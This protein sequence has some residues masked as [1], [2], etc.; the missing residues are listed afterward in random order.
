MAAAFFDAIEREHLAHLLYELGPDAPTL[1]GP[2]T[3]RDLA[4]HLVLREHDFFAG[5]GLVI[6]GVWSRFAERRREALVQ[7][8]FSRLVAAIRSGPPRGFFR[9]KWVR[10]L[11][12]LNEFFVHHEDVRR[13][14]G[15]AP[16]TNSPAMDA[17]LWRNLSC[18]LWFL[19]RRLRGTGLELEWAG[20]GKT[21]RARRGNPAA[22]IVGLPGELLLY[23][24]GRQRV[25]Q[26]EVHGPADAIKA[27]ERTQF[28]M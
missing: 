6:P 14:N 27:V 7:Q 17:A 23:L 4:A 26:V 10:Q 11:A 19:S 21:L 1:L 12:N 28:G 18:A 8:D 16:R 24:F 5:P 13:A 3:T 15:F 20:T 9:I 22:R 25:A 2:W